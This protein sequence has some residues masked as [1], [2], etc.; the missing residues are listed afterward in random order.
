[1]LRAGLL[2]RH[3]SLQAAV[4][5]RTEVGFVFA[6]MFMRSYAYKA[7]VRRASTMEERCRR[8]IDC[9]KLTDWEA[10]W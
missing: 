1:M 6:Q 5:Y 4:Q 3:G 7:G 8:Y 10:V 9:D 2:A